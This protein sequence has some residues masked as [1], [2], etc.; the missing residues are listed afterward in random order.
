MPDG[1]WNRYQQ[2]RPQQQQ[3][4]PTSGSPDTPRQ[5]DDSYTS[6]GP[7][8]GSLTGVGQGLAGSLADIHSVV[9]SPFGFME[10]ENVRK[11]KAEGDQRMKDWAAQPGTKAQE[12]GKAVG[13]SLPYMV[14]GPSALGRLAAQAVPRLLGHAFMHSM[15]HALGVSPRLINLA[16][17][18]LR[19]TPIAQAGVGAAGLAGGAVP[20]IY[21]GGRAQLRQPGQPPAPPARPPSPEPPRPAAPPATAAQD[22]DE[23]RVN[24]GAKGDRQ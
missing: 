18:A 13:G 12:I 6:F 20:A 2:Q 11:M 23:Q 14:G 22:D 5:S 16:I 3:P 21:G 9:G 19:G 10:P 15:G 24:R 8:T 4:T 7:L 17:H 1:P